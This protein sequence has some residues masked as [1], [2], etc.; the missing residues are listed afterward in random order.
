MTN[1]SGAERNVG[2][3]LI[4]KSY[5][6]SVVM[7][8]DGKV[9]VCLLDVEIDHRD[10]KFGKQTN[11]HLVNVKRFDKEGKPVL[12]DKGKQLYTNNAF[13][14]KSQLD[15]IMA[16]AGKNTIPYIAHKGPQKGQKVGDI[17]VVKADIMPGLGPIGADG[18]PTEVPTINAKTL[19]ASDFDCPETLLDDQFNANEAYRAEWEAENAKFLAKFAQSAAQRK[20]AEAENQVE[21]EEASPTF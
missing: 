20:A 13:Y 8:E 15:A 19:E 17:Y 10:P 1:I 9:K 21:A 7:D 2:I 5:D 18:K 12:N 14:Q 16:T 4:V 3:N 6:D 11:P